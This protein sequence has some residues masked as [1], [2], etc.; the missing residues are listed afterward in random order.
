MSLIVKAVRLRF[1]LTS[2]SAA[3]AQIRREA[4]RSIDLAKSVPPEKAAQSVAVPSMLGI[5]P[6]MRE[7][8]LLQILEHNVIVNRRITET[9]RALLQGN[10]LDSDDFDPKNDVLPSEQPALAIIDEFSKSIGEHLAHIELET[11]LK[12]SLTS[13]HPIFGPFDPHRW[14]C[15][16]GFHLQI[17][18]K[19]M[20]AV[21]KRLD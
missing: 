6:E 17:H 11:S 16:F 20:E 1:A 9:I 2:K 13:K 5:D 15:M 3:T 4:Q 21:V 7:W 14:H 19:Q 12:S 10:T 18:R 8:S